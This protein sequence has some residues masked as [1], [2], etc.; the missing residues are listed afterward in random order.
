MYEIKNLTKK[1]GEKTAVDGATLNFY[2]GFNC[3]TGRSGSGKSTLLKML[4]LMLAP[5]SGNVIL[6]GEDLWLISE[7]E[8]NILRN[9]G[10]GF[11]F[12]N[13]SL[14]P[15][16]TVFENVE[17]PL[18]IAGVPKAERRARVE[19]CLEFVGVTPL[20]KQRAA[21]LS[22]G[23]QQRAA[24][25]RAMANSPDV[26]LA[27]EPC[28]NLDKE[29]GDRIMSIFRRLADGGATVI[30]ITHNEEDARKTDRVIRLLDGRV[31][32]DARF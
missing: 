23:E 17:L 31:I 6:N 27:D 7:R 28:G 32:E 13:Y 9:R 20:K 16:Y 11:V 4:G 25:A 10:L 1:F 22:G 8:R 24:I 5:D 26:L 18:L 29:N 12:Q 19:E 15:N 30:M 2:K 3:I 21:T 14:E